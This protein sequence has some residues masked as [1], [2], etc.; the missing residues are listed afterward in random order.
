MSATVTREPDL[1]FLHGGGQGSWVWAATIAAL[2]ASSSGVFNRMLALDI[3][4]CGRKRGRNLEQLEPLDVAH[5]L[6]ADLEHA[7]MKN[8]VLVGHSL[9]GNVLPRLVQLR[10]DLFSRLVYVSCSIPLP[11]QTVLQ[12]IGGGLHGSNE[13]EVGWPVDA[14]TTSMQERYDVMF[15]NDMTPAQKASFLASLEHDEWPR[16]YFSATDFS[17]PGSQAVPAT[18]VVCLQDRI[19]PVKWQETFAVR[20]HATRIVRI[21]AGHQVMITRPHALAEVLRHEAAVDP[22]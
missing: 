14:R 5:E 2:Q 4:G 16:S 3:P 15:C 19:L 12:L 22:G 20:F 9:A 10:P 11:G 7:G 1:A 8:V 18:Y 21:D 6:I 13:S 17:F